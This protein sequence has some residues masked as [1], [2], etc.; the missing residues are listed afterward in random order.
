M[1]QGCSHE[2]IQIEYTPAQ[3]R[4]NDHLAKN[5]VIGAE[6]DISVGD[7]LIYTEEIA[8]ISDKLWVDTYKCVDGFSLYFPNGKILFNKDDSYYSIY[9]SNNANL[10]QAKVITKTNT[11]KK[12]MVYLPVDS[13]GSMIGNKLFFSRASNYPDNEFLPIALLAGARELEDHQN[14]I[15]NKTEGVP[16]LS[17]IGKTIRTQSEGSMNL[18]RVDLIYTGKS[19][20]TIKLIQREYYTDK[21]RDAFTHE[22]SYDLDESNIIRYKN[23]RIQVIDSTNESIKYKVISD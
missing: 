17:Y 9:K 1:L 18:L 10:V 20:N 12:W 11:E 5:Y 2:A 6:K 15:V 22:L 19:K 16:K 23:I 3:V 7:I 14:F 21:I 13:N 4:P 8:D